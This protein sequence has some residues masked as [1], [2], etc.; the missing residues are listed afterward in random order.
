MTTILQRDPLV[1]GS[2]TRVGTLFGIT[3]VLTYL[4]Y[5]R[6]CVRLCL[7]VHVIDQPGGSWREGSASA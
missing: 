2:Y 5:R 6:V 3:A 7:L 4:N 1:D